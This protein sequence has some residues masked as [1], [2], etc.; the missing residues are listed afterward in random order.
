MDQD[1]VISPVQDC[2]EGRRDLVRGDGYEGLLVSRNAKLEKR[3]AVLVEKRRVGLG[4]LFENQGEHRAE[5]K[6]AEKGEMLLFRK[7]GAVDVRVD[8]GK[9]VW[10]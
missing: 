5:A 4:V 8:H 1:R 2:H 3:D 10:G 6:R 9:V 7:A